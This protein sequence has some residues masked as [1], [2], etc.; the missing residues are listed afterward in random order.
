MGTPAGELRKCR[1]S[2]AEVLSP[3]SLHSSRIFIWLHSSGN[4]KHRPGSPQRQDHGATMR[5]SSFFPSHEG[6]IAT[7]LSASCPVP[8][9]PRPLVAHVGCAGV[10]TPR[11]YLGKQG[12]RPL[13]AHATCPPYPSTASQHRFLLS[14]GRFAIN[15]ILKTA[16]LWPGEINW[17][18]M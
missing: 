2:W 7:L 5:P 13:L 17:P 6:S 11:P 4:L 16:S 10:T 14:Q 12:Q 18:E 8:L 3:S 9:P 1:E 15:D